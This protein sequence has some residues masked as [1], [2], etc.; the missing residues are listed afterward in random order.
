MAR[1][2]VAKIE[3]ENFRS[4]EDKVELIVK[5]GL[6]TVE[7]W[8]LDEP[9]SKNGSGK[10][11]LIS[12]LYWCLTGNALTNEPLADDVVNIKKGKDCKVVVTIDSDKG[13]VV[14]SRTR[15]HAELGNSLSLEIDGQDISCHKMIET[16]ARLNQLISVPFELLR[17]TIVM[18]SDM[19]NA[20][21]KLSPQQRVHTLESIRDY[22]VW[23]KIRNMAKGTMDDSARV[24]K[25]CELTLSNLSGS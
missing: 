17:S 23:E 1:F 7:G 4:V 22:S 13:E 11:T 14:V 3:I 10:S 16:Q 19:S 9:N 5:E 8:N 21:S 2:D 25:E 15:K 12:A 6:F 18:S 24:I 20:F